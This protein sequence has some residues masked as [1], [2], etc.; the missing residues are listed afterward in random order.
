MDGAENRNVIEK[1]NMGKD[2]LCHLHQIEDE[3]W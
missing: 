3:D 1:W 2:L